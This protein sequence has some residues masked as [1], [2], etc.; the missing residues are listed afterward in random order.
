METTLANDN[1]LK[2]ISQYDKWIHADELKRKIDA[3]QVYVLREGQEFIGWMRWG[4]FWDNTPFMNILHILKDYQKK[5]YGKQTV[6]LWES[7]MKRQGYKFVMTSTSSSET[8][9][10][11]YKKLGYKATGSFIPSEEP[12]EIIFSKYI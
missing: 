8:A 12:L 10:H 1:D 3:K 2:I 7:E 6:E 9:Q 4:L 11:F 5:G